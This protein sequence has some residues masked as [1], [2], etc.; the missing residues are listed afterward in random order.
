MRSTIYRVHTAFSIRFMIP[1]GPNS[2]LGKLIWTG[3]FNNRFRDKEYAIDVYNKHNER[4]QHIVPK[5][6]LLVSDLTK[7][8]R[9]DELCQFLEVPVP[10]VPFPRSND[11]KQFNDKI[12]KMTTIVWT[13]IFGVSV[14]VA[15]LSVRLYYVMK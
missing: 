13:V 15:L 3:K 8:G 2:M 9:W 10:D 6:R 1:K 4:V 5:D 14:L 12:D 11:T 7:N